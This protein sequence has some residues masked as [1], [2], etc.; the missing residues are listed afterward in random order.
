MDERAGGEDAGAEAGDRTVTK[1]Q[2]DD[3]VYDF[4]AK[5]AFDPD[6]PDPGRRIPVCDIYKGYQNLVNLPP[7]PDYIVFTDIG[8]EGREQGMEG[9]H[10]DMATRA[11]GTL[12]MANLRRYTYQITSVGKASKRRMNRLVAV[13]NASKG[14]EFFRKLT[15]DKCGGVGTVRA[16]SVMDTT[17][18]DGTTNYA[19]SHAADFALAARID[20]GVPQD[21]ADRID[22]KINLVA[23]K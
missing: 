21:W 19:L 15:F 14:A 8:D 13:F 3:A 10:S 18:P 5:F 6:N 7:D 22:P 11:D 1:D 16:G 23:I 20:V 12:T 9:F 2:L 4:I 17:Q